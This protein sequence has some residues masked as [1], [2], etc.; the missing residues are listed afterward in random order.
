MALGCPDSSELFPRYGQL[1]AGPGQNF[2][3]EAVYY[4][5]VNRRAWLGDPDAT[6]AVKITGGV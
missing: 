1:R 4:Q 5:Y 2:F 3:S 6:V